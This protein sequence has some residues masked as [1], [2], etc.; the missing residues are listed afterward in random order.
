MK[1]EVPGG[2]T[3]GSLILIDFVKNVCSLTSPS[4][5]SWNV[6]FSIKMLKLVILQVDINFE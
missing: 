6:S 2:F 3:L 5:D 1:F 4:T